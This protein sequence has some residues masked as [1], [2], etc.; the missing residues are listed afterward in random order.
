V[1]L[2]ISLVTPNYNYGRTLA[3]TLDSVLAQNYPALDYLVLDDGSTDDSVEIL[4]RRR[5]AFRWDRH[6]N[7]GQ[8]PTINRGFAETTGEIMGWINSD[9][10][11][12][13]W[14]LQT[15]AE[16]FTAFPEVEWITGAPAVIQNDAIHEVGPTRPFAQTA[17]RLGCYGGGSWG[18]VQQESTFWRRRLWE[19]AGPL[20]EDLR[21]AADFELWTRFARHAELAASAT[22]LGGF[23][24]HANNRSRVNRDRYAAEIAGVAA[25]LS[26]ADRA[27]R[28]RLQR[29]H[30]RYLRWKP[31]LGVKGL[32]RRLGGLVDLDG[33]VIRR[34]V[35][36]NRFILARE[37]VCP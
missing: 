13:P 23:T 34:D 33:Q 17:L 29:G 37:R 8:Y 27:A 2:S 7:R 25:E 12:L 4:R 31:V 36:A 21:F 18:V 24:I 3:R 5:G 15:V 19:R 11:L 14:T 26:P 20:R 28:A 35:D 16:I 1:S 22:V 6:A 30:E 32:V 10:I 9:D